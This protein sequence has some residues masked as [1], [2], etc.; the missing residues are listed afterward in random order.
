[1]HFNQFKDEQE[2]EAM[3]LMDQFEIRDDVLVG[4]YSK[5]YD[6]DSSPF[7]KRLMVMY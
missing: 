3:P 6:T 1:M 7:T 2:K 5:H 4:D